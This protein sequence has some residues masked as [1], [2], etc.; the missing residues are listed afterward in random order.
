M[1]KIIKYNNN[2]GLKNLVN[3]LNQRRKLDNSNIDLV[4]RIINDVKKNK[5]KALKK[6]EKRYSKNNQ[7]KI[8][9]KKN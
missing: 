7:I 8:P 1:I 2:S 6:Y 3:V 5:L 9:K 4:K